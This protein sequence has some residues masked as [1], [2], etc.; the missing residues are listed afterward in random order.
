MRKGEQSA[1]WNVVPVVGTTPG[2]RY[3]HTLTYSKPYLVTYGGNTGTEAVNDFW[4]LNVENNPFAWQKLEA[5]S[6]Q[7]GVRVYHSAALCTSGSATGM[8]VV[9]G[10]RTIKNTALND[11]WGLRRH[12]DGRWDWVRAPYTY[13]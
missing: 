9:F 3:G 6:E 13:R 11:T 5:H 1:F 8:I 7:P 2:R 10:G 4:C 12:R